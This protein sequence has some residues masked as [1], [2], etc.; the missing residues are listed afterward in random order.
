MDTIGERDTSAA[1]IIVSRDVCATS[2]IMPA[3]SSPPPPPAPAPTARHAR[4]PD[5]RDR[6]GDCRNPPARCARYASASGRSPPRARNSAIRDRSAPTANPFSTQGT[7]AR[8]PSRFAATIASAPR[9]R[10]ASE[11]SDGV[12]AIA[13]IWSSMAMARANAASSRRPGCGRSA[14]HRP[15]NTR[16]SVRRESSL[17]NRPAADHPGTGPDRSARECRYVYPASRGFDGSKAHQ[18]A[19]HRSCRYA[20]R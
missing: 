12:R 7:M 1:C 15:Q 4:F 9:Q 10:S 16:R 18:A 8:T 6:A 17:A 11:S 19:W 13:L 5:R 3:G 2:T 14:A 20:Y